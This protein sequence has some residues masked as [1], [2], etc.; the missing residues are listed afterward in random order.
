MNLTKMKSGNGWK[1]MNKL[2]ISAI[3]CLVF[4][5]SA[6]AQGQFEHLEKIA[7]FNSQ[8]DAH[9][10]AIADLQA[11]DAKTKEE[12]KSLSGRLVKLEDAKAIQ[13]STPAPTP[14]V[15]PVGVPVDSSIVSSVV[16]TVPS[17]T[18][19]Y[20]YPSTVT[21]STPTYSTPTYSTPTYSTPTYSRPTYPV[22]NYRQS[23]P[24]YNQRNYAT[25]IRSTLG[26]CAN[27]TCSRR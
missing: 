15:S 7:K 13:V 27:G 1:K 24:Y 21:Y 19:V 20:S 22:Y 3:I 14:V 2:A 11:S 10:A 23:T 5:G 25:P 9:E 8:L 17:S 12:L 18:V 26:N 6:M 16:E 4:C